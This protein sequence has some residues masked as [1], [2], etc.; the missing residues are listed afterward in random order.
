MTHWLA[1]WTRTSPSH[2]R[3]RAAPPSKLTGFLLIVSDDNKIVTQ[4]CHVCCFS[5]DMPTQFSIFP[6]SKAQPCLTGVPLRLRA[7]AGDI[8]GRGPGASQIELCV[9]YRAPFLAPKQ[10]G[11]HHKQLWQHSNSTHALE[12]SPKTTVRLINTMIDYRLGFLETPWQL[13]KSFWSY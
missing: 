1:A 13:S 7:G 2:S 11:P 4:S 10:E 12:Q 8:P 6:S 3:P 9:P 5:R